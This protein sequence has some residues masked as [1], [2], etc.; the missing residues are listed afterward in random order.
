M[1]WNVN[2]LYKF[3]DFIA[4]KNQSNNITS[5]NLFYLFNSEQKTYMGELVGNWHKNNPTKTGANT[6]IIEDKRIIEI[7]SPFTINDSLTIAGGGAV[8][9]PDGFL[10]LLSMRYLGKRIFR[11]N[12]DQKSA[13]NDSVIDP[14]SVA[15]KKI[16]YI[17]YQNEYDLLPTSI[18]GVVEFDYIAMPND[19]VWGYTLD[20]NNRQVY[21]SATSVQPLWNDIEI[22]EIVKRSFATLGVRLSSQDFQNFG[23]STKATGE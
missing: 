14:A 1:A 21:N 5:D 4:N 7:L 2:D 18:T 23:K 15:D 13:V 22:V 6:G 19:V 17:E 8:T 3:T 12:Q 10:D 16:Y 20:G 11:I 9:K